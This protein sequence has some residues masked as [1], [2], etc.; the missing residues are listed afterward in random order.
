M[1][2]RQI[3]AVFFY[4]QHTTSNHA[5]INRKEG[6][7]MANRKTTI[8]PVWV[9]THSDGTKLDGLQS[10]ST[11]VLSNPLC[12]AR[13][14]CP[15]SICAHCYAETLCKC[16]TTLDEHLADNAEI[17]S[18]RLLTEEE[19]ALVPIHSLYARIESFGDVR[20]VMTARNYIRIIRNHPFQH[21][22]IWSKNP[23][24]WAQAF[25]AE[26]KPSN[27]TYVHSSMYLNKR[28][29]PGYWFI[30]HVFTVWTPEVYDAEIR[31]TETECAGLS[32][33]KCLKC[34]KK[35]MMPFYID[36]RKR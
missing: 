34:Y 36:E 33:L 32:C 8:S 13:R 2:Q 17:L 16:R 22:G 15:D 29:N 26:G 11:S 5:H 6:I 28:E 4:A 12:Q 27:C 35:D 3:S 25:D 20:D 7:T 1:A 19:A 10:I 31:G 23:N 24:L 18:A 21:F 30:D 14:K 9:T